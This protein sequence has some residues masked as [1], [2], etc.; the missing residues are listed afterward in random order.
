[1]FLVMI[2]QLGATLRHN[3]PLADPLN[4]TT[5]KSYKQNVQHGLIYSN[6]SHQ[7]A[8]QLLLL[9][10]QLPALLSPCTWTHTV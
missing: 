4:P 7:G 8:S 3:T 1:M 10:F 9:F 2:A 6:S 5:S